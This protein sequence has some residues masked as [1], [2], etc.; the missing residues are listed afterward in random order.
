MR[1]IV[2]IALFVLSV[3][4]FAE[5][6]KVAVFSDHYKILSNKSV[7]ECPALNKKDVGENQ[8]LAEFLIF[9]NALKMANFNTN[10][11][12]V[13]YP[14][15][16]RVVDALQ[17]GDVDVSGFGIWANDANENKLLL[18]AAL[19]E[20]SEFSKGL[21]T[22]AELSK[23]IKSYD[24]IKPRKLIAVANQNW[25]NDW[26][27]LQCTGLNL[28]HV[29]QYYQMFHLVNIGRADVFPLTF[30]DKS[31]MVRNVFGI[32]MYPIHGVKIAI[33]DSL[34]FAISNQYAKAQKL[35]DALNK[36]MASLR[37]A[38]QINDVY[39]KLG[40][41]NPIVKNWRQIGC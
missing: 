7:A 15:A 41:T 39:Q 32:E 6:L 14:I 12:L 20:K 27:A 23:K 17:N 28:L 1:V 26:Q 21:Y 13:P 4:S 22:R 10:I 5:T 19:L 16:K 9:C 18:S 25:Q 24:S 37:K 29:D 8:M 2:V 3:K 31:D 30:G 36:G 34:H 11:Q 38:Q 35:A 33:D 40:I